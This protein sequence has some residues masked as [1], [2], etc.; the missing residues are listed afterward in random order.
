MTV[1][2]WGLERD[3]P[4][5]A[6]RGE[7]RRLGVPV[8]FLDQRRLHEATLVVDAADPAGGRL[9]LGDR[10]TDLCRVGAVY[11]RPHDVNKVLRAA[12]DTDPHRVRHAT[13]LDAA[14]GGWLERTGALVVNRPSAGFDNGSKPFQVR[15][16]A[17]VG[18]RIPATVVT[19][20]PRRVAEFVDL[21]RDVIYKSVSGI[22]SRVARLGAGHAARLAD[23]ATCPTQFQEWVPGTDVRVHVVGAE[24]FAT[25]V[26]C[27]ADD[28]RYATAQGYRGAVLR[29]IELPTEVAERCV[30]LA[31]ALGLTVAGIDLRRTP[32]G[33]WYGFEV[34]PSPAF[35][36]YQAGT[37]QPI[38]QTVAGLLAAACVC[39]DLPAA[40]QEVS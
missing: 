32:E 30:R 37:G 24:V 26:E 35:S 8:R 39:R 25:E 19:N 17:A 13:A 21:H 27:D 6:V 34:N 23:V 16:M 3:V 20:D 5:A 9:R 10:T 36:Y 1:L 29:E 4:L 28:Y 40:D 12:G 15:R 22:R 11:A 33:E 38:A 31:A 7:L 14:M 18:F 2:V